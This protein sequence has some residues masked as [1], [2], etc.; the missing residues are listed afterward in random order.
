MSRYYQF[1]K[2]DSDTSH[3]TRGGTKQ[4]EDKYVKK[5]NEVSG[6]FFEISGSINPKK[7]I[8]NLFDSIRTLINS[9][10]KKAVKFSKY[11]E[12]DVSRNNFLIFVE[13]QKKLPL[14]YY[15]D[16][17]TNPF[18]ALRQYLTLYLK[19]KTK[20]TPQNILRDYIKKVLSYCSTRGHCDGKGF[21]FGYKLSEPIEGLLIKGKDYQTFA[22]TDI[23]ILEPSS[24]VYIC[25]YILGATMR[26]DLKRGFWSYG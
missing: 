5:G 8:D 15:L 12:Y 2:R 7:S 4:P 14:K 24:D 16:K 25:L 22:K 6:S 23:H 13:E 21:E 3:R 9:D 1:R 11:I 10:F 17:T 19:E 18:L 26:I 20:Q